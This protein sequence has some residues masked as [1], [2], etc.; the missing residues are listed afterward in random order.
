MYGLGPYHPPS[1]PDTLQNMYPHKSL[2]SMRHGL[3]YTNHSRESSRTL[4]RERGRSRWLVVV[5]PEEHVADALAKSGLPDPTG[6]L[7]MLQQTVRSFQR[8]CLTHQMTLQLLSLLSHFSLPSPSGLFLRIRLPDDTS[9]RITEEA[10]PALFAS[11][12]AMEPAILPIAATL[13]LCVDQVVPAGSRAGRL[14]RE[15]VSKVHS[16]ESR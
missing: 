8:I 6:L 7:V 11:H 13:T 15:L 14:T 10:W 16:L 12:L 2:G 3:P 4:D 9:V 5:K 1:P